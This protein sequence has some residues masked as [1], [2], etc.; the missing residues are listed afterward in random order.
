MSIIRQKSIC[1]VQSYQSGPLPLLLN[2]LGNK[3]SFGWTYGKPSKMKQLLK[4]PSRLT[5][6][7]RFMSAGIVKSPLGPCPKIPNQNLLEYVFKD[8]DQWSEDTATVS[9]CVCVTCVCV[10][11]VWEYIRV[12]VC[13]VYEYLYICVRVCLNVNVFFF[14][15]MRENTFTYVVEDCWMLMQPL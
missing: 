12:Y 7:P 11:Y 3:R 5:M 14:V 15:S 10:T 6:C 1:L 2:V 9:M 13:I 8:V 4:R